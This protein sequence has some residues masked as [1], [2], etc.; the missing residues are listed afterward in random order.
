M[1]L[2]EKYLGFAARICLSFRL[3]P[4]V[5]GIITDGIPVGLPNNLL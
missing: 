2:G 1:R 4:I 3:G 5:Q